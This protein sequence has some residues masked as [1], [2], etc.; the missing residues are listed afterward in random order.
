M[1]REAKN[2]EEILQITHLIK[3]IYPKTQQ[4]ENKQPI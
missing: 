4:L 3:Y 1:K 2:W